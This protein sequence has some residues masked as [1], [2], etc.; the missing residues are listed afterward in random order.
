MMMDRQQMNSPSVGSDITTS[1]PD[2]PSFFH[3]D[4]QNHLMTTYFTSKQ[5]SDLLHS[6]YSCD[7]KVNRLLRMKSSWLGIVS[8]SDTFLVALKYCIVHTSCSYD[9]YHKPRNVI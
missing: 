2:V 3:P 7:N 1:T 9:S 8:V 4:I 6:K 5:Q